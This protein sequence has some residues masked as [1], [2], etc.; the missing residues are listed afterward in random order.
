MK[1]SVA[2]YSL[3]CGAI[4]FAA[5]PKRASPDDQYKKLTP[6]SEEQP[7]APK[8]ETLFAS[9]GA[10]GWFPALRHEIKNR[11]RFIALHAGCHARAGANQLLVDKHD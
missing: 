5:D 9:I 6:D 1:L 7:G 10:F 2:F 8:T 4:C 3:L 11:V